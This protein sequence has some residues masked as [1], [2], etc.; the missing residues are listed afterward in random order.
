[1]KNL[2]SILIIFVLLAFSSGSFLFAGEEKTKKPKI[3]NVIIMIADGGGFNHVNAASLYQYG[4][5]SK[6]IYEKFPV[7]LAV[8]TYQVGQ[9]YDPD[10]AWSFFN[11]VTAEY[12]DSS[13]AATA[14]A[15]GI[16]SYDGAIG[17]SVDGSAV[18]NILERAEELGKAT[19]VVT[20]VPFSHATPAGF[21]AH[22][23]S[24]DNYAEIANE[25]IYHSPV[26]LIMGCGH[27]EYNSNGS[28]TTSRDYQYVGGSAT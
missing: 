3:K 28:P 7:S 27:P 18:M 12:T 26:D 22:N 17:V 9:G 8:S 5:T 23:P 14:M 19:G 25:M 6:Q 13:A 4:C 15:S 20:S 11:Y 16:K 21:V 2:K 10:D 24:R 1:M